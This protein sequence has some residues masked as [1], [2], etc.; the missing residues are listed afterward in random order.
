MKTK[1]LGHL[2]LFCIFFAFLTG[3][4]FGKFILSFWILFI[5]CVFFSVLIIFFYKKE[6]LLFSD[7]CILFFF[8]FLGA[9]WH[10]SSSSQV[11]DKFVQKESIVILKV[12]SLPKEGENRNTFAAEIRKINSHS[13][14]LKVRVSDYTQ[15]MDYL[16]YYQFAGKIIKRR[17]KGY[18][19]Y[20]LN[21]KR[22]VEVRELPLGFWAQFMRKSSKYILNVFKE[23]CSNQGYRFLS[24]VFLG[25]KE[26]LGEEREMF[27]NAG[28]SHLLA[29]SGLHLG[30]TSLI[31]FF[32]LRFFNI[33]FRVSLIVSL[34]FLCFYTFLTGAGSSTLRAV[35][36]YAVFV[37]SFFFQRKTNLLNSLALAGFIALFL[38]SSSLFTIGF[39]L[40]FI[41]VFAIIVSFKI[42]HVKLIKIAWLH[43]LKQIF[44]CSLFVTLFLTPVVS[45]YFGKIYILSVFYNVVLIPF[46]TFILVIN[47]LLLIFSPFKFLAQSLGEALSLFISGF[48]NLVQTLGSVK[49]SFV[50]YDFSFKGIA[51]YYSI[52]GMLLTYFFF[53]NKR[54]IPGF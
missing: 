39:Q 21:I 34:V 37:F 19:Y 40:S 20:S 42:F 18:S 1:S 15:I 52:L 24:G 5:G 2:L 32:I 6:K 4:A 17:Y 47:F 48:I 36:M 26:L 12:I 27:S 51:I 14:K 31:L 3:V 44:F 35:T 54:A 38:E 29:I 7:I 8:F 43:Y 41:S 9:L 13:L 28:V 33:K 23:N 22:N 25:R 45:Y 30:L 11:T 50:L 49:F 46:F 10:L 16:R 53:K